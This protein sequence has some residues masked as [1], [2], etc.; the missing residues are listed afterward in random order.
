ML[1]QYTWRL[2]VDG[3]KTQTRRI[4]KKD[5]H[6]EDGRVFTFDTYSFK[7]RT[8]WEVG[9]T[10][11]VQSGRGK[12]AIGRIRITGIREQDVREI[13]DADVCAEGFVFN[14]ADFLK[15]WTQMHDKP[16]YLM[17][18]LMAGEYQRLGMTVPLHVWAEWENYLQNRP[19]ERYQAWVLEFQLVRFMN[20][21]PK[22]GG[23][24]VKGDGEAA[25]QEATA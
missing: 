15:T 11:A 17:A 2:V 4:K 19:A 7:E 14:K 1:F 20:P 22:G 6:F 24:R 25:E 16:G 5:E 9:K 10:Y 13:S 12:P 21:T 18:D 3:T 8:R 23:F